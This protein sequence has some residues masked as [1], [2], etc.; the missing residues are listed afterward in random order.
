MAVC[1]HLPRWLDPHATSPPTVGA[2]A[3][4]VLDTD[5]TLAEA[6]HAAPGRR[7]DA[8]AGVLEPMAGMLAFAPPGTPLEALHAMALGVR[9]DRDRDRAEDGLRRMVEADTWGRVEGALVEGAEALAA[10]V[11]G[12]TIPDVRVLL[13]LGDAS[14]D[15][16]AS[17][18]RGLVGNG[19]LPGFLTITIVPNDETLARIEAAAVHELHHQLRYAPGG[20]VWDP[21]TVSVGE[22]VVSEGLADAFAIERYG[23]RLGPTPI[24]LPWRGHDGV[25]A[26]VAEGLALRGMQHLAP[27]VLGDAAA[28]RFGTEPVGVPTGAA[29]ALGLEMVEQHLAR[30]GRTAAQALRDSAEE[31]LAAVRDAPQPQ[32]AVSGSTPS[33]AARD[34]TAPRSHDASP[35]ASAS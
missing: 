3:I 17:E 7:A 16:L 28:R 6:L 32:V 33:A 30:S 24:G 15:Y 21:A 5:R 27:W 13:M 2:M 23:P 25:L 35:G 20:V 22:H 12:L 34:S 26:R 4:T 14:D 10:A 1:M 18:M 8:L 11:P 9:L 31:V 29:Y 19:G